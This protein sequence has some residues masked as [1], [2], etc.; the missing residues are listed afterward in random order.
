MKRKE[1]RDCLLDIES[2][3]CKEMK[4][5]FAEGYA[6][7]YA[8]GIIIAK[9]ALFE[10]KMSAEEIA[11]ITKV[12]VDTIKKWLSGA[13]LSARLKKKSQEVTVWEIY[14]KAD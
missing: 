9:S 12:N 5:I 11:R 6:E 4:E 13:S 2:M 8:E 7:G 1:C 14:I 10:S 3:W